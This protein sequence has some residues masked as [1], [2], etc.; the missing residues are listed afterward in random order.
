LDVLSREGVLID[1]SVRYWRASKK[2]KAEDLGLDPDTVTNHLISLG[3][4]KLLPKEALKTFALIES[5]AHSLVEAGTFPFLGGLARFLPNARLADTTTRLN[6][7]EAEFDQACRRFMADYGELRVAASREWWEAARKLVSDPDRLVATI[8]ASFP[9]PGRMDRYFGFSTQMF[10]IRAPESLGVE[11]IDAA[12]QQEIARARAQAAA[13][14]ARQINNG[15]QGFVTDCVGTLREE[16]ATLCEQMLASMQSGQTGVHQKTLNRLVKFIDQF[17]TL[18]FAGDQEM[19]AHLERARSE[20]L[21]MS[22]E[23]YRDSD[24]ARRRL[25]DG[26]RGLADTAREMARQDAQDVVERF[27]IMGKRK[28]NLAA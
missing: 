8:E 21:S 5:R 2:L 6:E 19:E 11:L 12:D 16:T 17:K 22:A 28:F 13:D 18:N 24:T 15:V 27:G 23:E 10:Q 25:T 9:E 26:L 14:A 3:H 20:L 7:L 1:V 4:K